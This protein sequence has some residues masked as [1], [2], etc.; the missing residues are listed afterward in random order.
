MCAC[1][2]EDMRVRE[3][4]YERAARERGR[5]RERERGSNSDLTHMM[6]VVRANA[7]NIVVAAMLPRT[8]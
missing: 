5:E 4:D 2:G 7:K 6:K 1:E 3:E 8:S